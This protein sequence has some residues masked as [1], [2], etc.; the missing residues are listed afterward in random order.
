MSQ[1]NK[2]NLLSTASSKTKSKL[3]KLKP[4]KKQFKSIPELKDEQLYDSSSSDDNDYNNDN[5][6]DMMDDNIRTL[7]TPHHSY[8]ASESVICELSMLL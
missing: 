5:N 6:D 8:T 4:M 2:M 7:E 3:T 1:S